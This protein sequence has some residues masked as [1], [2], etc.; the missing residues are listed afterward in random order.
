[1]EGLMI[2]FKCI[3][4]KNAWTEIVIDYAIADFNDEKELV[5]WEKND[6]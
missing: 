6:C 5:I 1:M 4:C 2:N 3:W